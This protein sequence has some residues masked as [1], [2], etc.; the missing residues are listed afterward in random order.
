VLTQAVSNQRVIGGMVS[1]FRTDKPYPDTLYR[2]EMANPISLSSFGSGSSLSSNAFVKNRSYKAALL[3]PYY[4][5]KGN[6]LQQQK[7]G[8][9]PVSYIWGYNKQYP[10]AEVKNATYQ[11]LVTKLTQT[12]VDQ[13]NGAPMSDANLRSALAPLRTITNAEATIYTYIPL[14]GISSSTDT[15]GA[16][17]YYDYDAYGR[18]NVVRDKDNNII[19]AICYNYKG[20]ATQDCYVPGARTI[21]ARLE[22]SNYTYTN[23]PNGTTID[24]YTYADMTLKF[25]LD[26]ACTQP[27]SFTTSTVVQIPVNLIAYD[28]VSNTTV[29]S[30]SNTISVTVPANTSS[31]SVGNQL[32]QHWHTW[33]DEYEAWWRDT[34]DFYPTVTT[35][36]TGN[37]FVVL[38]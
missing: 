35:P 26:V 9:P 11:D 32:L 13:I 29:N 7:P 6:I 12:V 17:T 22:Y 24:Y 27:Y 15:R 33:Y 5:D 2:L 38:L 25:Y 30:I 16:S 31:K 3:I 28:D 4:D 1:K 8:G 37:L 20:E 18:L 21:Y 34:Y 10:V 14:L 19:K 23:I 36:T